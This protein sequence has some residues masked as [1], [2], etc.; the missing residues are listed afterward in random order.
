[1]KRFLYGVIAL[2]VL[3]SAM[4]AIAQ[5]PKHHASKVVAPVAA[6][7]ANASCT[8]SD[9]SKCTGSCGGAG[10]AAE[11]ADARVSEHAQVTTGAAM[12]SGVNPAG[13][14]ASCR[15]SAT[16]ALATRVVSR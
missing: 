4:T 1:M 14:P 16:S 9:P 5:T 8:A 2:G 10:W 7:S 12:C 15:Q 11:A 6:T 13:C 3:A